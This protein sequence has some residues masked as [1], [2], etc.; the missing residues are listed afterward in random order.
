MTLLIETAGHSM[1]A[2]AV[3]YWHTQQ[4]PDGCIFIL[5]LSM[6]S[7]A[8]FWVGSPLK[9]KTEA[10]ADWSKWSTIFPRRPH[11]PEFEKKKKRKERKKEREKERKKL[12][13][14]QK[15]KSNNNLIH[16]SKQ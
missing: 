14:K 12:Y 11:Q 6:G 9:D 7:V 15:E 8:V 10:Y 5:F 2:I 3:P 4:A 1:V 13:R 16:P